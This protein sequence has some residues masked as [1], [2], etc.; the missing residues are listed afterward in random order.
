[1]KERDKERAADD[2]PQDRKGIAAHAQDEGFAEV[3]LS[4]DPWPQE[5]PNE[6]DGGRNKQTAARAAAQGATNGAA[7]CGD[8]DEQDQP[9]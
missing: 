9:R 4:C 8:H 3:Q 1:M 2:R 6:A 5:R 7:E